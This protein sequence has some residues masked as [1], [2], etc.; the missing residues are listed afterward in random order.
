LVDVGSGYYRIEGR[1]SGK[2]LD[3]A[4]Q[5]TSNGANVQIY[6]YWGGQNQQWRVESVGSGYYRITGRQSGKVLD[7]A[8]TGDGANVQIYSYGGGQ[9]QQWSFQNP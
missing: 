5:S 4:N 2:V 8:G 7:A 9:N 3:V 6:S 1:Q